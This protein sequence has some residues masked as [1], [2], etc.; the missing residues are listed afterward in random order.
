MERKKRWKEK[1]ISKTFALDVFSTQW[2]DSVYQH[3]QRLPFLANAMML[4]R[5][6]KNTKRHLA[7]N[8]TMSIPHSR[9]AVVYC[10]HY[11]NGS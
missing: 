3:P 6:A 4:T 8:S 11:N 2:G 10:P 5:F 9:R 1:K 7:L